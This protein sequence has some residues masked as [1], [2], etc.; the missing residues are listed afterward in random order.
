MVMRGG[1]N[2]NYL[3]FMTAHFLIEMA[4]ES[5]TIPWTQE[6]SKKIR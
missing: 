2:S 3:H 4:F 5:A 1:T 6:N